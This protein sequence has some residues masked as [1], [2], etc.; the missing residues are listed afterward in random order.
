MNDETW[1]LKAPSACQSIN[2]NCKCGQGL[3]I[4]CRA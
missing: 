4:N 1:T 3:V 2:C